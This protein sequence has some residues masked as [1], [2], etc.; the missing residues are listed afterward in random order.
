MTKLFLTFAFAALAT[1][2]VQAAGIQYVD[3][4]K[5][6]VYNQTSGNAPST[7]AFY[8]ANIELTSQ[9]PGDYTGVSVSYPGPG[10][11]VS[12]P[13]TQPSFFSYGPSFPTAAAMNAAVPFGT[14]TYT[15]TNSSTMASASAVLNYTADAFTS[16][17]PALSA[18]SFNALSG[19]NP[20]TALSIGF[21]S[22]A[23]NAAASVAYTFFSIYNSNGTAFSDGFLAPGTT[24]VFL[25][26]GTLAA[27]T[28]YTFELDFSD[29][30]NGTDLSGIN[31]E[32]GS[33]ARTDGMFTTGDAVMAPEPGTASL[34]GLA[35]MAL[36][37]CLRKAKLFRAA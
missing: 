29:R 16:A 11:P 35:V 17:I 12:L 26:A 19:L 10:S 31:T 23:P 28:T 30:V 24:S 2:A 13:M 36:A 9:N 32:V 4:F 6:G 20:D 1:P 27:D 18:A 15:A 37:A 14:Y 34:A 22:F 21:N 5:N 3:I 7:A 33:D 8:F 25:P